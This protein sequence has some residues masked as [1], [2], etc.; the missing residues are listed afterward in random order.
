MRAKPRHA[1]REEPNAFDDQRIPAPWDSTRIGELSVPR[2]LSPSLKYWGHDIDK[3]AI[4]DAGCHQHCEPEEDLF[5][6]DDFY[7]GS[8]CSTAT[9][10]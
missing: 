8:F 5:L 7:T 9:N 10:G 6:R 1:L 2:R 3:A 4:D